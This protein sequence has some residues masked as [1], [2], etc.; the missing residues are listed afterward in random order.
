M[1]LLSK[2]L[3]SVLILLLISN[4]IHA[5]SAIPDNIDK[6]VVQVRGNGHTVE[7]T[8]DVTGGKISFGNVF[9]PNCGGGDFNVKLSNYSHKSCCIMVEGWEI[10]HAVLQAMLTTRNY[11]VP[12]FEKDGGYYIKVI[13]ETKTEVIYPEDGAK[14]A[15]VVHS[16]WCG[17]VT[18]NWRC[19]TP[20]GFVCPWR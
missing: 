3:T 10:S 1:R 19:G 7:K 8:L 12:I 14:E 6:L 17:D 2:G 11:T 13:Q 5:T 18:V 20:G 15:K 16:N 4:P 9:F